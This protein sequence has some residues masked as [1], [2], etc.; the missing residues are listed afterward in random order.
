MSLLSDFSRSKAAV[1]SLR[2]VGSVAGNFPDKCPGLPKTG[3]S[4]RLAHAE[5]DDA[6]DRLDEDLHRSHRLNWAR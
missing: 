4:A 2:L 1:V 6:D 3:I 5:D